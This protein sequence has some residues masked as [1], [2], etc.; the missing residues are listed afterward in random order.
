MLIC[1]RVK[2]GF[3]GGFILFETE[4]VTRVGFLH[5]E[6]KVGKWT[7]WGGRE[8]KK[9]GEWK[10]TPLSYGWTEEGRKEGT[11]GEGFRE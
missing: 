5:L 1:F 10:G 3:R 4:Y 2:W 6:G 11:H 8:G 9:G 7:H